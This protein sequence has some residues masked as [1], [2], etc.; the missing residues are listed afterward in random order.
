V[1][2]RILWGNAASAVHGAATVLAANRPDRA[3][4][5]RQLAALL[6]ARPP[7]RGTGTWTADGGFRRRSCC[8]IYRAAAAPEA[9]CGDCVLRRD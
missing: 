5:A 8:L 4:P 7:L 3:A 2:A 1:S 9:I 6:L